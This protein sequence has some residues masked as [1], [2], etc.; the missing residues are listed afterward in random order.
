MVMI[1]EEAPTTRIKSAAR[2][3]TRQDKINQIASEILVAS[4]FGTGSLNV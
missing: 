3:F 1:V 2:T 4:D